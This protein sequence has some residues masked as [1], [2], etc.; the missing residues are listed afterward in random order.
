MAEEMLDG[1]YT[2]MLHAILNK[3]W[4]QHPL[5][6]QLFCYLPIILQIISMKGEQDMTA[7]LE[8]F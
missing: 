4:K 8:I 1:N 5:R 7:L 6:Q 2:R 3:S